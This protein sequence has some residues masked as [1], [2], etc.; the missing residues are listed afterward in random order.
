[1]SPV[2]AR[3]AHHRGEGRGRGARERGAA[4]QPRSAAGEPRGSRGARRGSRGAAAERGGGA[5]GQPRSAAG[6]PRGSAPPGAQARTQQAPRKKRYTPS[7]NPG[8]GVALHPHRHEQLAYVALRVLGRVHQKSQHGGRQ[9]GAAHFSGVRQLLLLRPSELCKCTLDLFVESIHE[10]PR[11]GHRAPPL[12]LLRETLPLRIRERLS[13]RIGEQAVENS[14]QVLEME[15]D[16]SDSGR[17]TPEEF[18]GEVVQ[19]PFHLLPGLEE[20]VCDGLKQ[21]RYT[22]YRSTKPDLR[23]LLCHESVVVNGSSARLPGHYGT[24]RA[25]A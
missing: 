18:V 3:S 5:E 6:E 4:G 16:R 23:F 1:M 20:C 24:G 9:P 11:A 19:Q 13:P 21:G 7:S 8:C 15:A 14:G 10:I 25:P 12:P 22:G 2:V 17:S